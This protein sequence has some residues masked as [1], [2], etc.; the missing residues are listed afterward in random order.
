MGANKNSLF[1]F[2]SENKEIS[3]F[4]E[5]EKKSDKIKLID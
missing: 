1:S 3:S 5:Q 2:T 4:L